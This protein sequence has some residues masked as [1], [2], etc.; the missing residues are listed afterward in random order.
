M[1]RKLILSSIIGGSL[2]GTVLSVGLLFISKTKSEKLVCYSLLATFLTLCILSIAFLKLGNSLL[3]ASKKGDTAKVKSLLKIGISVDTEN[4]SKETP[5]LLATEGN[6]AE[7]V[8]LLLQHKANVNVR[9]RFGNTPLALAIKNGHIEIAVLLLEHNADVTFA[10]KHISNI[11]WRNNNELA[12]FAAKKRY[13]KILELLLR[14]GVDAD[15]KNRLLH[16]AV[17]KGCIETVKLLLAYGANVNFCEFRD[18]ILHLAAANG[19][20]EMVM[21]LIES[22]A[23]VNAIG[24][25]DCTPLHKAT[26][27]TGCHVNSRWFRYHH[28]GTNR[29]NKWNNKYRETIELLIKNGADIDAK[30]VGDIRPIHFAISSGSSEIA[31]LLLR[32]GADPN[33]PEIAQKISFTPMCHLLLLYLI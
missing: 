17:D 18:T 19:Q 25:Y 15:L 28:D 29:I 2:E 21:L 3:D 22:G 14:R 5:L 32:K 20:V 7:T 24:S 6:H 9:S 16:T 30:G 10:A 23:N 12:V 26:Q 11:N 33:L 8:K 27:R 1:N 13:T 4:S 31:I